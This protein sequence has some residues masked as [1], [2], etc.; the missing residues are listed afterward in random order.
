VG[1]AVFTRYKTVEAELL[2]TRAPSQ[3]RF[4]VA[5]GRS[6]VLV[7]ARSPLGPISFATSRVSGTLIL[8]VRGG[9]IDTSAPMEG[10]LEVPLQTLTSGN[11]L[12]DTEFRRRIDTRRHP[13]A[14]IDLL[15]AAPSDDGHGY[16]V[17]GEIEFHN[18]TRAIA[19]T[20]TADFP[21]PDVLV[22]RGEQTLDI[23]EFNLETPNGLGLKIYPDVLIEMHLEGHVES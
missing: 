1:N 12:Y 22:V 16:A 23:R 15:G 13:S 17:T 8:T 4:A 9:V 20:V 3:V 5:P 11:T 10:R 2:S 21:R 14:T 7:K 6:A 18:E 19:G